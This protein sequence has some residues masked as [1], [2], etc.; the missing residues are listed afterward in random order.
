MSG[1]TNSDLWYIS[2]DRVNLRELTE[3]IMCQLEI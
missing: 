3:E 2:I 1:N